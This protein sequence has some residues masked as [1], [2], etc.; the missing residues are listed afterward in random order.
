MR[1]FIG[2]ALV[3]LLGAFAVN[4]RLKRTL[5]TQQLDDY[6]RQNTSLLAQIE[7]NSLQNIESAR[8]LRSLQSELSARDNRLA[9]LDRE[10]E[11]LQEQV[12]PDYQQ[13]EARIRQQLSREMQ[14]ND[15]PSSIDPSVSILRQLSQLDPMEMAEIISLNGQYGAFI[16]GLNVDEDREEVI[17]NALRRLIADQNQVRSNLIQELQTNPGAA[18]REE[19]RQQMLALSSPETQREAL[20]YELTESELDAFD[21][22]QRQRQNSFATFI[23]GGAG[24]IST[25]GPAIFSSEVFQVGSGQSRSVRVFATNPDN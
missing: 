15:R 6:N 4:E 1:I 22:F 18:S 2:L 23:G 5:L 20:S 25:D 11:S 17:I 13:I 14:M 3:L 24:L 9:A 21:E 19:L 10:L 7:N 16:Q 12:D 8:T